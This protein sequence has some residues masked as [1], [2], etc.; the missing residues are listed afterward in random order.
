MDMDIS[1]TPLEALLV[2][3]W[4]EVAID[5]VG[6]WDMELANR[7]TRKLYASTMIDTVI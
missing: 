4:F 6:H 7:E 5:T 3:P 1:A 2:A